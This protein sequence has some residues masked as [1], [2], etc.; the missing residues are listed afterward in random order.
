MCVHV[1]GCKE[2]IHTTNKVHVLT[3]SVYVDSSLSIES[4]KCC[5]EMCHMVR[6]IMKQKNHNVM[7]TCTMY[8][9]SNNNII[10]DDTEGVFVLIVTLYIFV[11]TLN[12][13]VPHKSQ[14]N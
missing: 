5:S 11:V 1:Y 2:C 9:G 4:C 3:R 7:D 12:V 10:V 8:V 6:Q 14:D 13:N